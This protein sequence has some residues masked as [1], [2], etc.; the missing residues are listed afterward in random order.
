MCKGK[1]IG[2][3]MSMK[4]CNLVKRIIS[5]G[6]RVLSKVFINILEPDFQINGRKIRV[7]TKY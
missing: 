3:E 7:I 2:D 1:K 5:S 6:F 4:K